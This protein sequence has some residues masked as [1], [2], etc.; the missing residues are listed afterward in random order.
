VT[1]SPYSAWTLRRILTAYDTNGELAGLP[2]PCLSIA[3]HLASLPPE[4]RATAWTAMMAARTDR[5]E[6]IEALASVDPT[7]APPAADALER[8]SPHVVM[9]SAS[10]IEPLT[11]DWLWE[12]RLPLGMLSLFAGDPKLGTSF[13]TLAL[14]GAVSRGVPL[15]LDHRLRVPGSVIL[16]SAEDDAA[17]TIVP[18]LKA[19][20]ANLGK[21]HIL[22]A[23]VLEDGTEALP[24][25][26]TDVERIGDAVSGLGDC[27]LVVIDPVSAYLGGVDDH[28]N[29]ELRGVLS[30]LKRLAEQ[31]NFS[32]VLVSHLNKGASVNGKHRVTGSIAYVGACRA[33]FLFV[34]DRGDPTGHRVL[35]L[36]NGCNLA[37]SVPTLAYRIEDRGDGPTVEWEADPVPITAEEALRAET[38]DRNDHSEERECDRWLRDTLAAGPILAADIF[39]NG[40]DAGFSKDQLKRAKKRIGAATRRAGFGPESECR[41]ALDP[42]ESGHDAPAIQRTKGA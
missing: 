21:I 16:M 25:L 26:R 20:G 3:K 29:A 15:P 27:R 31:L 24:R 19:A 39:K 11:V 38:E 23:V 42:S 1:I 8:S 22:E 36:D 17:R 37:A 40:S 5:D 12:P 4:D 18:R 41:W 13:V 6:V 33:N 28:R 14:A 2:E 30:P 7:A 35:M 32:T 10:T 9:R 34:R